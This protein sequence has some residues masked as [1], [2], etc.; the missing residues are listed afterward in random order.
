MKFCPECGNQLEGSAG[1][2]GG[3][4]NKIQTVAETDTQTPLPP[5]KSRRGAIFAALAIVMIGVAAFAVWSFIQRPP[6]MEQYSQQTTE[7]WE[8]FFSA[9][10]DAE[11][12]QRELDRQFGEMVDF[13][14]YDVELYIEFMR[15][16][17]EILEDL[18]SAQLDLLGQ[19]KNIDFP[20]DLSAREQVAITSL[21]E[22]TILFIREQ[23]SYYESY[24]TEIISLWENNTELFYA[25][26]ILES[27][28]YDD[29][30]WEER[31][32]LYQELN[33][34]IEEI[35]EELNRRYR[36]EDIRNISWGDTDF[37]L[38][39]YFARS[40]D[41]SWSRRNLSSDGQNIDSLVQ[42]LGW[43]VASDDFI[44]S[45]ENLQDVEFESFV[46]ALYIAS[47]FDPWWW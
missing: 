46:G 47:K 4:G 27:D 11:V 7:L 3:C 2:C 45:R 41:G 38:G 1:F 19:I 18:S 37:A 29:S 32:L 14:E 35:Y 24:I 36:V 9:A 16:G 33:P 21:Y 20:D 42:R 22:N 8:E 12:R 31:E 23:Q 43:N 40:D 10:L 34:L 5:K 17:N 44:S 28:W 25:L 39:V 30:S 15:K 13:E 26:A 6:T